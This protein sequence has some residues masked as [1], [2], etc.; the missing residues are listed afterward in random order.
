MWETLI[1]SVV[2]GGIMWERLI[3]SVVRGDYYVG[4]VNIICCK[5]GLLC[6]RG[7]ITDDINLSCIIVPLTTDDINLFHIIVPSYN[8]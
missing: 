3:S 2:R 1:S 6:E 5:R 7:Y 8:R 4:E